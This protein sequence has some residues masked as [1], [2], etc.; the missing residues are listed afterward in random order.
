MNADEYV[1]LGCVAN[2]AAGLQFFYG[3]VIGR[4]DIDV[5]RAG[6]D[7]VGTGRIQQGRYLLGDSQGNVFFFR[8]STDS[9]GVAAAMTGVDG[10]G[11]ALKT[12]GQAVG[13]TAGVGRNGRSRCTGRGGFRRSR[14]FSR[15][16]P[17]RSWL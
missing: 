9:T 2:V 1:S 10:D 11:L 6:H 4:I 7:D 8:K 13:L 5:G 14:R 16:S 15:R 12:L 3:T 17:R